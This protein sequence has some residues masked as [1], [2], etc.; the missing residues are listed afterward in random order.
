MQIHKT[1]GIDPGL[2]L[3]IVFVGSWSTLRMRTKKSRMADSGSLLSSCRLR[4]ESQDHY[5]SAP[6]PSSRFELQRRGFEK[7]A[8]LHI[9]GHRRS[10]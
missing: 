8:I 6:L 4:V 3:V 5:F 10:V 2:D 1:P 7:A 9:Y